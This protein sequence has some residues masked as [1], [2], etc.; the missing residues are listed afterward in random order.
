LQDEGMTSAV[1][2]IEDAATGR[3]LV[4]VDPDGHRRMWSYPGASSTLHADDLDPE[5][6]RNLDA[7]HL[8]GYSLIR[9]G[10]REAALEGLRLARSNGS[11]LCTLDPNPPHL[12]ADFGAARFREMIVQLQF[13]VIFPNLEE[14]RLLS[15]FRDEDD[16]VN[17][18]GSLLDISPLVVITLGEE[19]CVVATKE[20][21]WR[22][23][24]APIDKAADATGAGDAF[25]AGFIVE[26]LR[27]KDPNSAA[28]AANHLASQIVSKV[29]AR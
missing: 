16:Y 2:V 4:M 1:R 23:P 10:P 26:Y 7:F 14:A 12:I 15:R 19:G 20:Q 3:V 28:V 25:A 5:W 21:T 13:D 29:G 17:L 27:G 18:A 22:V 9:E 6:F 8:T 24:A 11:P